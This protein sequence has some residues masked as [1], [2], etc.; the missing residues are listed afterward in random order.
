M[1]PNI[2]DIVSRVQSLSSDEVQQLSTALQSTP[3]AAALPLRTVAQPTLQQRAVGAAKKTGVIVAALLFAALLGGVWFYASSVKTVAAGEREIADADFGYRV[4]QYRFRD[5][6]I[7]RLWSG[8]DE[9]KYDLDGL[10]FSKVTE[11]RWLLN[12]RAIYLNLVLKAHDGEV[13]KPARIIYDFYRGEIYANSPLNL[14]RVVNK[15]SQPAW[16][17]DADFDTQLQRLNQ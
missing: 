11:E 15:Q 3:L 12:G 1:T 14:W 6:A 13:E 16:M 4:E 9:I 10:T 5:R 8:G 7:L 2:E 17:L